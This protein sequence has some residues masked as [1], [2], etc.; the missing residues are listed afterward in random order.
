MC[1]DIVDDLFLHNGSSATKFEN[2]TKNLKSAG[3]TLYDIL[4][5]CYAKAICTLTNVLGNRNWNWY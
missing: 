3:I 1:N 5:L 4:R 2:L